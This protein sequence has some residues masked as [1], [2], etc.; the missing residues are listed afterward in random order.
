MYIGVA[1]GG[2]EGAQTI[3]LRDAPG[4]AMP[5]CNRFLSELM[6]RVG[7]VGC[8]GMGGGYRKIV[9]HWGISQDGYPLSLCSVLVSVCAYKRAMHGV[10]RRR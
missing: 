10:G 8:W 7:R 6:C 1:L 4:L 2:G 5:F 3:F 9:S